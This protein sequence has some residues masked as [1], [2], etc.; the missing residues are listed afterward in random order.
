MFVD[1]DLKTTLILVCCI[2]LMVIG[3]LAF[4]YLR[5]LQKK[6]TENQRKKTVKK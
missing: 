4:R 6:E 5:K 1:G 3:I 2:I